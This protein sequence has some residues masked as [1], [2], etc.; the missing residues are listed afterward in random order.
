MCARA[1]SKR[2]SA[3][4]SS[5]PAGPWTVTQKIASMCEG[6]DEK[7]ASG[8]VGSPERSLTRESRAARALALEDEV[9]RVRE[10]IWASERRL[11]EASRAL[12]V[13]PPCVPVAPTTRIVLGAAIVVECEGISKRASIVN[14]SRSVVQEQISMFDVADGE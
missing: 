3:C 8:A 9:L 12:T 4:A 14:A 5:E 1:A 11:G 2:P 13:E 7:M 6:A 10:R